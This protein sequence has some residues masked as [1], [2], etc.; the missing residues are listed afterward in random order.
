MQEEEADREDGTHDEG[1]DEGDEAVEV[2]V[3]PLQ[4]AEGQLVPQRTSEEDDGDPVVEVGEDGEQQP[5]QEA[6]HPAGDGGQEGVTEEGRDT[7]GAEQEAG[8]EA[9]DG[10]QDRGRP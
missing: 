4:D 10:Q 6:D 2:E 7:V 8:E 5:Q 1:R 3:Q 9:P